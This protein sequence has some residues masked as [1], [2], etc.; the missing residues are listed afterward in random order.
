MQV[1]VKKE[2]M[3]L[4]LPLTERNLKSPGHIFESKKKK[5]NN[6]QPFPTI[7]INKISDRKFIL[8]EQSLF[9]PFP[10]GIKGKAELEYHT[11]F[12]IPCKN[13]SHSFLVPI[14]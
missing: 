9:S 12:G 8:L 4:Q 14:I 2:L 13:I 1:I 11:E 10:A 3:N 7:P 5:T 6:D